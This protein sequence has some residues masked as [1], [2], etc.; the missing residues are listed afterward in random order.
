MEEKIKRNEATKRELL[1][2]ISHEIRT[3]ITLIQG[4]TESLVNNVVPIESTPSYLKMINSK[5]KML[6]TLLEDLIQVSEFTS[7]NLNYKFYD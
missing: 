2:N 3:P 6:T 1:E 5:A 4:Y 7:Q